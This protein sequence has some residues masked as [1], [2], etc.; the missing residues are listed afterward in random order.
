MTYFILAASAILAIIFI[1]G[2]ISAIREKGRSDKGR[3]YLPG[4]F[5]WIG[6]ICGGAFLIPALIFAAPV[7]KWLEGKLERSPA[8]IVTDTLYAAALM[9]VFLVCMSCLVKGTYNP[10]IYFNF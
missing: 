8:P 1:A 7:A 4:T 5:A 10:F 3:V 9:G 2:I 6:G